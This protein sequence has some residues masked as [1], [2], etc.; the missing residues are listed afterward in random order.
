[1]IATVES[2]VLPAQGARAGLVSRAFAD[3]VDAVAILLCL[4]I[5]YL[6]VSAVLFSVRPRRFAFPAPGRSWVLFI[7]LVVAVCYLSFGW[8]LTGRTPGKQL[9]GLRVVTESG[10]PLGFPRAFS[11]AMLCLVFPIG[12]L[13]TAFSVKSSSAQDLLLR[14]GVIYDW[15]KRSAP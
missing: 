10:G 4:V 1:M 12:L 7:A 13:W 14:T 15:K 3:I 11:R 9:A 6:A 2:G 5:G 8:Y